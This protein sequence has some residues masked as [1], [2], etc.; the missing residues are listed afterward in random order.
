M[1]LPVLGGNYLYQNRFPIY[2][3]LPHAVHV[4]FCSFLKISYD[5]NPHGSFGLIFANHW[6][7]PLEPPFAVKRQAGISNTL[8]YSVSPLS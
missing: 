6:Q 7:S 1:D 4:S 3:R 2:N 5:L 8:T